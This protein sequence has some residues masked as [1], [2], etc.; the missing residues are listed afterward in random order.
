MHAVLTDLLHLLKLE[1]IEDNIFRGESRDIGSA[2]VFGGQVLA[3][4]LSAALRTVPEDRIAHSMHGYFL[5][6]GDPQKQIVY[7]VDPIRDGRSFTTR[8]VVAKQ[9]GR[10]IFNA[11]AR[12]GPLGFDA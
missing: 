9:H 11:F 5:R 10:A 3:Q 4:S 6:P 1:R 8:R 2:Q 12:R 7:E